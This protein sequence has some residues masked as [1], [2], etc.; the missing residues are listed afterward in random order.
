M[1]E[2]GVEVKEGSGDCSRGQGKRSQGNG[3]EGRKGAPEGE[4]AGEGCFPTWWRTLASRVLLR[5]KQRDQAF[6]A[7]LSYI[8]KGCLKN[9]KDLQVGEGQHIR[10]EKLGHK[11]IIF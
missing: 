8:V 4:L 1:R 9:K 2:V 3:D 7:S 6:K 5:L 10:H 11:D